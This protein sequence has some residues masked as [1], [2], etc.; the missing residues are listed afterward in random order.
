MLRSQLALSYMDDSF[1]NKQKRIRALEWFLDKDIAYENRRLLYKRL[2]IA[3]RRQK[4][5]RTALAYHRKYVQL[6]DSLDNVEIAKQSEEL[7]KKYQLK[8]KDDQIR[9]LQQLT[10]KT[11]N[12]SYGIA[13]MLILIVIL[14]VFI[15]LWYPGEEKITR[16]Y[17]ST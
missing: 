6:K 16:T 5:Y 1:E 4:D 13:G 8:L 7:E 14:S 9:F 11:K 17:V 3:Y 10:R 15:I 2:Y 12:I